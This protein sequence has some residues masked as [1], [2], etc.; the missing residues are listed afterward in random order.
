MMTL[1]LTKDHIERL[2]VLMK[3]FMGTIHVYILKDNPELIHWEDGETKHDHNWLY[4]TMV[5]LPKYIGEWYM[6]SGATTIVTSETFK[7]PIDYLYEKYIE[8]RADTK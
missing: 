3:K 8:K 1:T 7:H 4:I 6:D 5:V 2:E